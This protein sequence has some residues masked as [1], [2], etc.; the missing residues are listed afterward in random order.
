[1]LERNPDNSMNAR[2]VTA[3]ALLPTGN[4]PVKFASLATGK[5]ITRE[6]FSIVYNVPYELLAIVKSMQERGMIGIQDLLDPGNAGVQEENEL[7]QLEERQAAGSTHNVDDEPDEPN[8]GASRSEG[9][10]EFVIYPDDSE[11]S[12][13][14]SEDSDDDYED[15]ED[16]DEA[17]EAEV[18]MVEAIPLD[19][20][21]MTISQAY[22]MYPAAKVDEAVEKELSN[23]IDMK[24]FGL[25]PMQ[26]RAGLSKKV[27]VP[28]KLLERRGE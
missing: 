10:N 25:V 27:I 8:G 13:D 2:T 18:L 9:G 14:D 16:D 28:S 7:V 1:V 19:T 11:D 12:D 15:G 6:R 23:M 22:S 5:T 24:V 4:G 21:C 20:S 3:L 26:E 17:E